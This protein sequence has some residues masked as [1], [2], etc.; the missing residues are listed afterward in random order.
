MSVQ[1]T[2][3]V[4]GMTCNH[5]VQAVTGELSKLPGVQDVQVDLDKGAVTVT[6]DAALS[7]DDVRNAVDEAGY[8]LVGADG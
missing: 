3:T 1:H 7:L 6:S 2:Y 5:C 8:E 4:T